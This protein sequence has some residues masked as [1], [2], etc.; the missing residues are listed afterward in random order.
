MHLTQFKKILEKLLKHRVRL[1]ESN[2]QKI[3]EG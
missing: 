1:E 2:A 3:T